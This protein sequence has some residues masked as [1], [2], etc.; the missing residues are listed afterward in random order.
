LEYRGREKND[1][2][3]ASELI[4]G[5]IAYLKENQSL[6]EKESKLLFSD[7]KAGQLLANIGSH[8]R[9]LGTTSLA[10]GDIETILT[11]IDEFE[12]LFVCPSCK[13]R[14]KK[15]YS[16]RNSKLKQCECGHLWI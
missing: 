2:R 3:E 8:H 11:D 13:K 10:R 4:D 15:S 1:Q 12:T 7:L 9:N 16:P 14:A 5:L 6:R